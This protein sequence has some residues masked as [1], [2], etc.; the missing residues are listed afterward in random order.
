[1]WVLDNNI[2]KDYNEILFA[3]ISNYKVLILNY[4]VLISNYKTFYSNTLPLYQITIVE[5]FFEQYS[6]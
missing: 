4:R 6:F 3:F 2:M 1:M 5:L